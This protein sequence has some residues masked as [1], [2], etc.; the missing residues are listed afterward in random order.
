MM[1]T[2]TLTTAKATTRIL[3]GSR[4]LWLDLACCLFRLVC[5]DKDCRRKG[6]LHSTRPYP[7]SFWV[8]LQPSQ[9][10]LSFAQ[11]G[12]QHWRIPIAWLRL[13]RFLSFLHLVLLLMYSHSASHAHSTPS[14]QRRSPVPAVVNK[15]QGDKAYSV[16]TIT[17]RY[18][19]IRNKDV[20]V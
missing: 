8:H 7:L 13:V 6:D 20:H 17:M 11:M 10:Y 16:P 2:T 5:S 15:A 9:S 14:S 18:S 4:L 3:F 19:K 12:P 1:T